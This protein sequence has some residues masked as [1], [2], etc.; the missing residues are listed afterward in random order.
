M[1]SYSKIKS[2]AKINLA[3]NIIGKSLS[4]HKIETIISF[5]SLNDEIFVKEINKKKHVIKFIGKFSKNIGKIN[6]ISKLLEILDKK[7]LLKDKK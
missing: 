7:K 4:I 1:N 3:L 5:L 6:T 2:F